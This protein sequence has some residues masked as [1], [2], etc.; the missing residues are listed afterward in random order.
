MGDMAD[1]AL[2]MA[3]A[4]LEHYERYKDADL[5]T[6]YDE[7]IIDEHGATIGIPQVVSNIRGAHGAGGCPKCGGGT[8]KKTGKFGTFYGCN[9]FP[10]CTGSRGA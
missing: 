4:Q 1:Y 10:S 2:D 5:A 7:G 6:Q 9:N 8:S 3:D